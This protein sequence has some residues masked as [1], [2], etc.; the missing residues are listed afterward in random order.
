MRGHFERGAWRI[1]VESQGKAVQLGDRRS[2]AEAQTIA[3]YSFMFGGSI[4]ALEN[5][6]ALAERNARSVVCYT[7]RRSVR[8]RN[9]LD[10]AALRRELDGI[11]DKV[12]QRLS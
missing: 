10:R 6:V 9:D 3:G 8:L 7:D 4:E 1:I 5:L 11:I 12:G 2:H